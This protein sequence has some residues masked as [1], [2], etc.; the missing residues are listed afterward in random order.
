M[1]FITWKFLLFQFMLARFRQILLF[2][3][4]DQDTDPVDPQLVGLLDPDPFILTYG[5]GSGSGSGDLPTV[6]QRFD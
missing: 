4:L 1:C 5:S 2:S 3:V 6:Y